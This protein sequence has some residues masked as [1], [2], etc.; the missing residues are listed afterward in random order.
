MMRS[1]LFA[2]MLLAA[3]TAC[4]PN[5]PPLR[6]PDRFDANCGNKQLRITA[7]QSVVTS[8]NDTIVRG[9]TPLPAELKTAIRRTGGAL[10]FWDEQLLRVPNTAKALGESDGYAR[11]RAAA[12]VG[13]REF[14]GSR[15]LELF[16]RDHGRYRWIEMTAFD[17]QNVC[18][19]GRRSL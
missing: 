11:M 15:P 19:E 18:I 12:I 13:A 5:A 9:A 16:V 14:I 7:V 1:R 6:P 3:A 2:A 17:V 4:A 10:V 8:T